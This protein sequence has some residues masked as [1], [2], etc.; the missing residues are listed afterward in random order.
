[1]E[2][3]KPRVIRLAHGVERGTVEG[4]ET[5]RQVP[6]D[7]NW[8]EKPEKQE[9]VERHNRDKICDRS[10]EDRRQTN[11]GYD[12]AEGETVIDARSQNNN[13]VKALV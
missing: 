12:G 1:M 11:K 4:T 8:K 10:Y 2:H 5:L 3:T 13:H 9:H 7:S 6:N